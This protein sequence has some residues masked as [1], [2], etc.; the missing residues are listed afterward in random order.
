MI[1]LFKKQ[2]QVKNNNKKMNTVCAT[3]C[4]QKYLGG[5]YLQTKMLGYLKHL[6]ASL[7]NLF[8][9]KNKSQ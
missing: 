9:L 7:N 5:R 2:M 4:V 8:T 6:I 1:L 3:E